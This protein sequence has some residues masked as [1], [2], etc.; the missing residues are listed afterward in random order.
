[1]AVSN[2]PKEPMDIRVKNLQSKITV[3]VSKLQSAA[4]N[5]VKLL[6]K[7]QK[8]FPAGVSIAFVGSQRM[9]SINRKFLGHDYV[10]DV[11]T[12][13]LEDSAEIIICPMVAKQ[14]AKAY[15]MS[16]SKELLLY[17][18]HGFLH[19]AGFDDHTPKDIEQMRLKENYIL[20]KLV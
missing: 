14:N 15:N 17:V 11:I 5:I 13:D 19:L 2:I 9:R 16:I 8:P 4:Q 3:S 7:D 10:T 20:Q 6:S 1:M 12:F 18:V